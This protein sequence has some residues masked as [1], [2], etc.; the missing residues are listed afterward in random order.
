[1]SKEIE[2]LFD[3]VVLGSGA[4]GLTAALVA[5]INGARVTVL[6]KASQIGGTSAW[7]GGMI[8]IPNNPH[9]RA[10]GI[11]DSKEEALTYLAA[12]SHDLIL[13]E[14]AEAYVDTGPEMVSW[15]EANTSVRFQMVEEFPDYHPEF[16]GGKPEGGRS[17]ECPLMS[18]HS[19][20]DAAD[21]VTVGSNYGT[22]PVSMSES[23]LGRAIPLGVSHEERARRQIEDLRGC[24]QS[25]VGH[26][27][28]ACIEEGIEIHTDS[29]AVD[30]CLADGEITGVQYQRGREKHDIKCRAVI[31]ASGGFEWNRDMVRDFLRGPMTHPVSVPSNEGDAL[32][33]CMRIGAKL[34]NM[35][36][37]WWMP[38]IEVPTDEGFRTHLFASERARPR[39]IMVNRKGRRFTNE[40]ANYNAFGAAFHEQDV[41]AFDYA[42]LPC[43][44]IF[45]QGLMDRFGF[46]DI[47][48]GLKAPNWIAQAATAEELAAKL[49]I[50]ADGLRETLQHWNTIV[51]PQQKDEAFGRG[52]SAH[53]NW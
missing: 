34:G 43:W 11:A 12:L 48:K 29:A 6:E 1:M 9:M 22:A 16:P 31:L 50:N 32:K 21:R 2:D 45:D 15:L 36:E 46:V 40:A 25:L 37:A 14:L 47:P 20:G 35:R 3:V 33:M 52:E 51:V 53:D 44:F 18:F 26:L 23:N 10:A 5:K 24:G 41:A 30:L 39:S 28:R 42:N 17:L 8:W 38:A 4:A 19:L 13:P 7:S 49:G 27:F